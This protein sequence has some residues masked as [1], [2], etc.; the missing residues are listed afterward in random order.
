MGRR[1][2][3]NSGV[4]ENS[5]FTRGSHS[6]S[7]NDVPTSLTNRCDI[8]DGAGNTGSKQGNSLFGLEL[9]AFKKNKNKK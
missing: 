5:G 4:L 6:F 1:M 2:E 8:A 7:D 3:D 9:S